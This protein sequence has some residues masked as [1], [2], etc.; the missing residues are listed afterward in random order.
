LKVFNFK[1]VKP[2]GNLRWLIRGPNFDMRM[3]EIQ[4]KETPGTQHVHPWEHE[5]FIVEGKG[6][7]R[8]GGWGEPFEEGDVI[9]IPSGE[10]H[11]FVNKSETMLRFICCIPADVDLEQIKPSNL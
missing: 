6:E 5:I 1:D 8:S 11:T 7:A 10:P 3:V 2:E 4:P 9:H